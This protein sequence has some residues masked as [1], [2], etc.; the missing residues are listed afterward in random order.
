[1]QWRPL[2]RR[3]QPDPRLDEP[4][5][6]LPAHLR[7]PVIGWVDAAYWPGRHHPNSGEPSL[8]LLRELQ[9]SMRLAAPLDLRNGGSA[10]NDVL[11]RMEHD[12]AFA[13][14]VVDFTLFF[15]T[16]LL[17]HSFADSVS[18][19]D[20]VL[21]AGGS[22]WETAAAEPLHDEDDSDHWQLSRRA[23]GPVRDAIDEL[24]ASSRAHQ[25]LVAAWNRLVGRNPDPSAAYRE[26]VRA[27]EAAAKPIVEPR[28]DRATLG[29]MLRV[30]R[31]A[32][33][34][35]FQ[36]RL[37][38]IEDIERMMRLVW[39]NQ[40]DRHGTDDDQT[41]FTVSLEDA[42]VAVHLA[43]TLTRLFAGGHV[44]RTD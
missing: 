30:L 39:T 33:T 2:S 28:N 14:D 1:M 38:D 21:W 37:G 4:Y 12:E 27:I 36:P 23:I 25:H 44:T 34:G 11:E 15:I 35:R 17:P 26:A 43:L 7:Q 18:D 41:P 24:P 32:P 13:L 9:L 6:G 3:G 22:A 20:H 16:I 29:T 31:D 5:E 19:L 42:D 8:P 10:L 40:R